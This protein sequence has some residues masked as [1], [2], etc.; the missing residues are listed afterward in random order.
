[1]WDITWLE[2]RGPRYVG[3]LTD[4]DTQGSYHLSE[5]TSSG[6]LM[7]GSMAQIL[8]LELR[9]DQALNAGMDA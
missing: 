8:H 3:V 2:G 6:A 5:E 9:C 1:M 4:C 7:G